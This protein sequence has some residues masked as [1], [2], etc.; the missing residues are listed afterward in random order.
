L[1]FVNHPFEGSFLNQWVI[2]YEHGEII[3]PQVWGSGDYG[4]IENQEMWGM[5]AQKFK[6]FVVSEQ[7]NN[8]Y[9]R[10]IEEKSIADLP[11]GDVLIKVAF[12]SL[13]YKDALSAS[14]NRGVTRNY[15]HTP[16]IDAA[17]TV[18]KSESTDYQR[19]DPVLVTGYDLGMNTPGGFGQ[20]IRVPAEWVIPL[21]ASLSL[22]ESM[23][24]GTAGFTAALSVHKLLAHGLAPERGEVLVTGASGGVGSLSIALLAKNGFHVIAAT[25]KTERQPLLKKLGAR[26]FLSRD[27][28]RDESGRALLKGRW[29]GAIDTVGGEYLATA[30]KATRYGGAV[31]S[32]GNVASAEFSLTVYPF[33]LRSVS[34]LGVDSVNCPRDLRL[35]IWSKLAGEWK[36]QQLDQIME[37][38]SL[39]ELDTHI[40]L[41][42][43]GRQSGRVVI[44]LSG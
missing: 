33:I 26:D 30:L 27:E 8:Q 9:N 36:V 18:E 20:Y 4:F 6:A 43:E 38:I 44:D 2:Q 39:R 5:E 7:E 11:S 31:A 35:E 3:N 41:I 28:A 13:N 17:G 34:L 15:P 42:L 1:T 32:C 16:G 25:G 29:A 23:A 24:Y 10:K 40:G 14:G 37:V 12:S 19:G 22:K 21:P